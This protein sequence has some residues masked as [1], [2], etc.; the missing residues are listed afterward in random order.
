MFFV[1]HIWRR[2]FF[3]LIGQGSTNVQAEVFTDSVSG[4]QRDK[5]ILR[6]VYPIEKLSTLYDIFFY[7]WGFLISE[8]HITPYTWNI[9]IS[10]PTCRWLYS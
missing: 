1:W 4:Q 6:P 8:P 7:F 10:V 9:I 3:Q 2:D 5:T